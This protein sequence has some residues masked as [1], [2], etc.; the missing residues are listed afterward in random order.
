MKNAYS[1]AIH[2]KHLQNARARRRAKTP[3]SAGT[4]VPPPTATTI[5]TT[6]RDFVNPVDYQHPYDSMG[7]FAKALAL[8]Y[9]ANRTR[10]AYYRQL[11]LIHA[12]FNLDPALLTETQLR[13]Y[14]LFVKLEK[15]WKP[16]SIRQALAAA[17][18]FFVDLLG[19][20]DWTVFGQVRIQ[21]HDR[22]PAVLTRQQVHAL[23]AHIRLRRYRTPIK[24]IYVC[25]L[26][27][28]ECLALT[29]RD[30]VGPE[31]KLFIRGGKGH[32]DRVVPLPTSL[33]KE[34]RQY[35][36]VH[37]HPLLIFPNVGRG[38][39]TPEAVANRMHRAN[40]PMACSSLQRLLV[41]ARKHLDIP[42]A[43]IHSLRH[44]FATHLLEAGA[45]LHTIQKLLGHKQITSTMV[46]LH[47][48]HQT[49]RDA[50]GLMDELC[51]TLPR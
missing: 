14:F 26:R 37:R 9:D 48:T 35:W 27:L 32:Q 50:L 4:P 3:D 34:L 44:S 2:P 46:Y 30:I 24:L 18:Q 22:L 19:H 7:H 41:L 16:N 12:H 8:R 43:S 29:V 23:P 15:H 1:N 13:D 20:A 38:E 47:L 28:S 45:H 49:T 39:S 51:R 40:A 10:H 17:R 25:G 5:R 21:E 6:P 36:L 11:R 42:A 31:N 33:Y